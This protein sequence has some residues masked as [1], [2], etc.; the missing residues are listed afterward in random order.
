[1]Y[2]AVLDEDIHP[3]ET[4]TEV[5]GDR[6]G[7]DVGIDGDETSV[8]ERLSGADADVTFVTSRIPIT[9]RVLESTDIRVVAKSGTGLDNVDLAAAR[10]RGVA[11]TYTPGINALSVAEHAITLLL[12][13]RRHVV[14]GH[15]G[16]ETGRWRDS[17]P[18]G[19]LL[20]RTTVG[21]VGFGNIGRRIATLLAGFDTT[22]LAYDPY[23][24][25]IEGEPVHAELTDLE[26]VLDRSDSVVVAAELTEET[27]GL[28]DR[29]ALARMHDDAVLVAVSRGQIVDQDA[30]VEALRAGELAG[31]GLDVH[32]EEPV[33]TDSPMLEFENVVLTPHV[34]GST[35]T[36]R[37]D[38]TRTLAAN[39]LSLLE[40]ESV[41]DRYLAVPPTV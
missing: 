31:A 36:A 14:A 9:R 15:R 23:V 8:V 40:G 12:A 29:A 1:M 18:L 10:E 39:A 2:H 27:R 41:P 7:I 17:I 5:V 30:L 33:P 38:G 37:R 35:V 16:L 20:S 25:R 13:T 24:D 19:T 3:R 11:V 22:T 26:T 4:L 28:L 32:A 6:I 21:I 34:G